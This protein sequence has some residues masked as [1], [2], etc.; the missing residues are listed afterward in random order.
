MGLDISD[1]LTHMKLAVS[2]AEGA[3]R[4][5]EREAAEEL[6]RLS[7]QEVPLDESTLQKSGHSGRDQEGAYV[8]YGGAANKY[9]IRMHE[10]PE[11]K[12]QHGRKGKY[13]EDPLKMN[14]SRLTKHMH[15]AVKGEF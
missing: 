7:Q 12:F 10:H 6:L 5:G 4:R 15:Q 11:Y 2:K 9:A 13:L 1:F 3:K 8:A 14:I